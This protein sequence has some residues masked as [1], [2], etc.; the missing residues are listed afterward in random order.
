MQP[1]DAHVAARTVSILCLVAAIPS[2]FFAVV[3][4][5]THGRLA[6]LPTVGI[7]VLVLVASWC[8]RYLSGRAVWAWLVFPYLAIA[9]IAAMDVL[10]ADVSLSAQVFLLF[11]V[12]FAASQLPAAGAYGVAGVAVSADLVV[13]FL[14]EPSRP[15][16]V[17]ATYLAAAL[18]TTTLLLVRAGQRQAVLVAELQR[19]AA[20]DPLTGLVTRRILD[21]TAEV[22]LS[23]TANEGAALI[24][25][26]IDHFKVVN[27]RHGHPAG[28]DVLIS[29]A[30]ILTNQSRHDDVVSRM[31][32]DEIALLLPGC[33]PEAAQGRA[34]A[35]VAEVQQHPFILA[36]GTR[37]ALSVSVGVAHVPTHAADLQS[38][39]AAADEA[40][41]EA[42]RAGRDRVGKPTTVGLR[43][44]QA[45]SPSGRIGPTER[46]TASA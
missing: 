3:V 21:E 27:D 28:D 29:I 35:I 30:D 5:S 42:K 34:E 40:L 23:R 45:S 24:L 36:D 15:A 10:T 8:L 9:I 37:L 38:L 33:S 31:G 25:V 19:L 2:T 4:P 46:A 39:Y 14:L 26:D 22:A 16:A 12:L 18:L 17:D 44:S 11:P 20:I 32:G 13:V 6:V 7:P 1:R 43:R 41:Y